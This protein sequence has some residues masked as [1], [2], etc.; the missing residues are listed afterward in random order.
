MAT[1][2]KRLAKDGKVSY[3]VKIRLKGYPTQSETFKLLTQAKKW[4]K[5][6]ES[7]INEGRYFKSNE[8]KK[9]TLTEMLDRYI[10]NIIP[11]KSK[12][13][14]HRYNQRVQLE[15]WKSELGHHILDN[16]TPSLIAECR[17][18][19]ANKEVRKGQKRSPS[20]VNR[21][22]AALSHAFTIAVKEWGWIEDNPLRKVT[23]PKE[24]R[25]RVRYLSEAERT[26]LLATCLKS[27]QLYLYTLVILAI[28][29]GARRAE[30]LNLRWENIDF[31]RSLITLYETKK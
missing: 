20:T 31:N 8:A 7:A 13:L 3:R 11:N 4:E 9:H 23:K 26:A 14:K 28:S 6:T 21:Y 1:I 18:Q 12:N 16:V 24:S 5:A 29:T 15:W 25:G 22:L 17:D 27:K 19:L 30:L 2:E 10:K